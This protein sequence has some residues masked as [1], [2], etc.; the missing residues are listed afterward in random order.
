M[1]IEDYYF[2]DEGDEEFLGY[3]S[4]GLAASV[5]LSDGA[6]GAWSLNA[7]VTWLQL[8]AEGLETVNHDDDYEIIG[9]VGV[10]FAY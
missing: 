4:I 3:G 2:D 9:K 1:S 10:S 5:P 6:Y 7:S 8:F